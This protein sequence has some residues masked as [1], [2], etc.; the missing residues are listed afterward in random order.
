MRPARLALLLCLLALCASGCASAPLFVAMD[1]M[2]VAEIGK[3]G[4]DMGTGL[5]PSRSVRQDDSADAQA[6]ARL[7][8][9]LE[10]QGGLLRY[11]TP[12]V[13]RGRGFVVGVYAGRQELER[14]RQAMREVKGVSSVTLCLFPAGSGRGR[15]PDGEL[16]ETI[17]QQAGPRNADL[18]VHVVE[19]NAVLIGPVGSPAEA[20]RLR[21]LALRA[22]A[23]N[24]QSHLFHPGQPASGRS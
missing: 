9:A 19:G 15:L 3:T 6:E 18:R 21:Q 24:V 22:G 17:R 5:R 11:A 7:R 20:E 8:A 12:Q 14:A 16:R 2:T 10:A 13:L 23:A 4:Y 1:A